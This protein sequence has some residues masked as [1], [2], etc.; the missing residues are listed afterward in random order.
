LIGSHSSC[1]NTGQTNRIHWST[2]HYIQLEI[3]AQNTI[4]YCSKFS[5]VRKKYHNKPVC[6]MTHLIAT[7]SEM[8][9]LIPRHLQTS[10]QLM[11]HSV[12]Q[13][14]EKE[15]VHINQTFINSLQQCKRQSCPCTSLSTKKLKT[16]WS[17]SASE[18][19]RLSDRRLS[20]R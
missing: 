6:F 9:L 15:W 16:P 11:L 12:P 4:H 2:V 5:E 14:A 1:F 17:E 18:L 10:D 8:I 13:Y 20:A 3:C 7:P 19:Y